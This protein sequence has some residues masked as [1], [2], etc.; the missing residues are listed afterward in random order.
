MAKSN[1]TGSKTGTVG[2]IV[3]AGLIWFVVKFW[4]LFVAIGGMVLLYFI[5]SK[6][7]TVCAAKAARNRAERAALLQR[8]EK[9]NLAYLTDPIAYFR[10]LEAGVR[11][12]G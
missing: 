12:E 11:D 6:M 7:F 8:C 9:Q 4:F 2:L 10:D 1:S 5:A 3:I